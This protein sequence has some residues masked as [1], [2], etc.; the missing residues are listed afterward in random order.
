MLVL[1]LPAAVLAAD[2]LPEV[3]AAEVAASSPSWSGFALVQTRTALTNLASTNPL[4]DGQV[5]GRLG[6]TNGVIVDPAA[7]SAYTEQRVG[8]F[9]TYRPEMLDGKAALT[10]AFEVDFAWGDRSYGVAGNTGAAIGGDMVNLQTRRLAA[11]FWPTTG[12]VQWHLVAGLQLLT[13]G[14][15]DPSGARPD[16]LFRSGGKLMFWGTEAAGIAAYGRWTD[17]GWGD[18]L[19]WRLGSFTLY[20]QGL[21][22]ADDVWLTV[23]DAQLRPSW[24]TSLGLHAW[25]LQ[26][27]AGGTA[28]LLGSGPASA[29]SEMQGGPTLDPYATVA[30]PAD[31]A[32]DADLVW[33]GADVGHN[34]D[35][36]Q[37][38]VG[39]TAAAFANVGRVYATVAPDI[40]VAGAL[41]DAELRVRYAPGRSVLRAEGLFTTGDDL[42]PRRYRGVVTGNSYGI[43]GALYASHGTYLLFSDPGSINRMVAVVP[44]V[45]GAGRGVTAVTAGA[46]FDPLPHRLTTAVGFG[47]AADSSFATWGTEGNL[48]VTA[49]PLP[50]LDL[51]WVAAACA[52]GPAAG[53]GPA[54]WATYLTVDWVV[55]P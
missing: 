21:A 52:P 55:A 23:A 19:V 51:S 2:P 40:A 8:A 30:R 42:D 54:A 25:Y 26:D 3:R 44:D 39:L 32:I 45:S 43:A 33:L 5:I 37:G 41:A 29:L 13:D 28:G 35:L 14:A 15:V 4:L 31:A 16:G 6:G 18:R 46:A 27:R 36:T 10:G 17:Q 9:A 20:E 1:T 7:R 48:R 53:G 34:A 47:T 11:E 24:T 49:T 12:P 50:L 22:T 38:P